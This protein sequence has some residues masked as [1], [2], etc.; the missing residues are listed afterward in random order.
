MSLQLPVATPNYNFTNE[1]NTRAA[2]TREDVRNVK[3]DQIL[4][5]P[6]IYIGTQTNSVLALDGSGD[7]RFRVFAAT[8]IA[9]KTNAV[10]T[11]NKAQGK[12]VW[13]STNHRLMIANGSTATSLWYSADGGTNVTPS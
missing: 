2:I 12:A 7:H 9:D 10:N 11:T 4:Y 6:A 13:D 5:I 8:A 3:R 1:S